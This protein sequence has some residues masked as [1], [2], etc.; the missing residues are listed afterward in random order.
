MLTEN[1]TPEELW[2]YVLDA[3]SMLGMAEKNEC[4]ALVIENDLSLF[5]GLGVDPYTSP[6][7]ETDEVFRL[8]GT[9]ED[10]MRMARSLIEPSIAAGIDVNLRN[11]WLDIISDTK[12]CA[13]MLLMC[14]PDTL[15][16]EYDYRMRQ[17]LNPVELAKIEAIRAAGLQAGAYPNG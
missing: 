7:R 16:P 13:F 12:Q 14:Y 10:H 6:T 17:Q 1:N 15:P 3:M 5:M 11:S 2:D 9:E 8:Y 4:V